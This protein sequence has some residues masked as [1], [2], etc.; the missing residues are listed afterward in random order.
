[1]VK[2]GNIFKKLQLNTI[3]PFTRSESTVL[4][5]DWH[6]VCRANNPSL[7][8]SHRE[9]RSRSMSQ[10]LDGAASWAHRIPIVIVKDKVSLICCSYAETIRRM[11]SHCHVTHSLWKDHKP[12]STRAQVVSSRG[13]HL[14]GMQPRSRKT[15]LCV[16][17]LFFFSKSTCQL[18]GSSN[19]KERSFHNGKG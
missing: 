6:C 7:L 9:L 8:W 12:L 1:M 14:L 15:S 5:V 16:C 3:T 11:S 4:H 13:P 2:L 18:F 17:V 10:R 19:R